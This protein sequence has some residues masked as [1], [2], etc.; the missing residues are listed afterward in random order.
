MNVIF[1]SKDALTTSINVR[2]ERAIGEI[3]MTTAQIHL[4]YRWAGDVM[5]QMTA[6]MEVM[7]QDVEVT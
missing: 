1:L 7:R 6:R 5:E 4:V 3:I 2:M